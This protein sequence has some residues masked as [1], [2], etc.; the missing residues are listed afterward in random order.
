[1]P[2]GIQP[3]RIAEYVCGAIAGG[4][5]DDGLLHRFSMTVWPDISGEFVYIDQR[6]DAVAKQAAEA[7]F[8]RLANPAPANDVEPD[9]WRFDAEAQAL[10][11]EWRTAFERELKSPS[12]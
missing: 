10:F 3:G 5:A 12:A 1:M 8:D 9:V 6:P 7:V 2:G 4:S 11:V